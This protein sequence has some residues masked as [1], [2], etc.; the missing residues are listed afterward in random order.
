MSYYAVYKTQKYESDKKYIV[1]NQEGGVQKLT[2][3]DQ[4]QGKPTG[5][6][7]V[8]EYEF[9][10]EAIVVTFYLGADA[11][12]NPTRFTY[13]GEFKY[14][15]AGALNSAKL[16][17]YAFQS[18]ASSLY[19]Y[20]INNSMTFSS[21]S[22][23]DDYIKN[24]TSSDGSLTDTNKFAKYFKEN[25]YANPFGQDLLPNSNNNTGVSTATQIASAYDKYY[26]AL[27]S[28]DAALTSKTINWKTFSDFSSVDSSF[29]SA[30]EWGSVNIS[31]LQKFQSSAIDW[32]QVQYSEFSSTQ[33]KQTNW[34]QVSV[35]S[36]TSV[37]Y[38]AIDWGQVN[39][40]GS[41]SI[42]YSE[43][44][45]SQ[46]DFGDFSIQTFKK[47]DWSQVKTADLTEQQY[48][49]INWGQVSFKGSKAPS[50]SNLDLS[51]VVGSSTFSQKAAKQIDWTQVSADDLSA[52]ALSKLSGLGVKKKGVNVAELLKP[53]T[54]S[55]ELSF[56][57][58]GQAQ[59]GAL[60]TG[61]E[62]SGSSAQVLLA[63]VEMQ[64]ALV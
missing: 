29:Y 7:S 57:G 62:S 31:N 16:S 9:S 45:W 19:A 10:K 60:T 48:S 56:A 64:Q 34:S 35:S 58:V 61:L 41:K 23:L 44:S 55:K 6:W 42:S 22:S 51:L 25:W 5:G 50:L 8:M 1:E 47:V 2:E 32:N 40:R 39:Y 24:I 15:D 53:G 3:Y 43:V 52:S 54:Q 26:S 49:E 4:Y 11:K 18:Y 13:L 37:Q 27:T 30:L 28:G 63:T 20:K 21:L 17:F 46:V 36:F 12:K 38:Q 59:A 33:Y 14:N